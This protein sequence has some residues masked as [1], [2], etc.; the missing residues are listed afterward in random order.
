M[1]PK[2]L[3]AK[4]GAQFCIYPS[5]FRKAHLVLTGQAVQLFEAQRSDVSQVTALFSKEAGAGRQLPSWGT[6]GDQGGS[7]HHGREDSEWANLAMGTHTGKSS[8]SGLQFRTLKEYLE[9]PLQSYVGMRIME[10]WD[11]AQRLMF[12]SSNAD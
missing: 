10:E 12:T 3:E 7:W 8:V 11:C 6:A 5:A 1:E 2:I 9:R 4:G